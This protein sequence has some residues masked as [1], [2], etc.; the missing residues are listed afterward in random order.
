[1]KKSKCAHEAFGGAIEVGRIV[2]KE[3]VE[4]V[5]T[6]RVTCNECGLQFKFDEDHFAVTVDRLTLRYKIKP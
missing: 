3:P 6:V 4:F 2:D 1:M 5:V